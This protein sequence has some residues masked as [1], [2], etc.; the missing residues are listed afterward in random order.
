M[1]IPKTLIDTTFL[2]DKTHKAFLGAE[3]FLQDGRI[4]KREAVTGA[5]TGNLTNLLREKE[6][7]YIREEERKLIPSLAFYHSRRT[8]IIHLEGR[9]G[10]TLLRALVATKRAYLKHGVWHRL[11]WKKKAQ[12]ELSWELIEGTHYRPILELAPGITSL[13]TEPVAYLDVAQHQCGRVVTDV[14]VGL[15]YSWVRAGVLDHRLTCVFC[16]NLF[17]RFAKADFPIPDG[18]KLGELDTSADRQV[19]IEVITRF[20]PSTSWDEG[21]IDLNEQFHL[22]VKFRYGKRKIERNDEKRIISYREEDTIVRHN[23]DE[24]WEREAQPL[25]W[26]ANARIP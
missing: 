18:V 10:F 9:D 22:K 2:F 24:S 13:A 21:G 3:I 11:H 1:V 19:M 20:D 7:P 25:A 26:E 12:A 17:N 16:A 4:L 6:R 8:G 15:A 14:P 5:I 23:R